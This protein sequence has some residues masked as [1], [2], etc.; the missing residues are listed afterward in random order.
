MSDEKLVRTCAE[1]TDRTAWDEFV[2]RFHSPISLSIIR[3]A[4]QWDE[5][6][7]QVVDDLI[8]DTFLK[9][10]A[11]NC[12]MLLK[13]A[14]QH[15]NVIRGYIKMIAVNV[16]HDYF[17]ST[18]SQKRGSGKTAQFSD[19]IEPQAQ[20]GGIGSEERIEREV[21]L[22]EITT[23]LLTC[24]SGPD[25]KRDCSV[26][27]LYYQ[28]GMT[29]KAIASMPAMGLTTKGVESVIFRLTRL[30][31]EEVVVLRSQALVKTSRSEK[32]S[33]PQNRID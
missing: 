7:Q 5:S 15:P 13:F 22:K 25:Q 3:T 26:F 4:Y 12:Q 32:G 19:E 31:R 6:P 23:S 8:Q 30:V 20:A 1:S 10:C 27:W 17:K 29:A 16:A 14:A 33:A 24:S 28:Q 21:L 18:H 11:D 2:S 9:L